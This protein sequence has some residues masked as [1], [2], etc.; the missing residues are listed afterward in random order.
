MVNNSG[1]RL[2]HVTDELQQH[3]ESEPPPLLCHYTNQDG[4]LGIISTGDIWATSVND[5]NDRSEFE[6]AKELVSSQSSIVG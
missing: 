3:I 1:S 4:L 2:L 6:Y 5:L